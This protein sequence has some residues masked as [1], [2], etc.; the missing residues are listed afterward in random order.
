[1]R[2]PSIKSA[3]SLFCV[4]EALFLGSPCD[5]LRDFRG[6]LTTEGT[7]QAPTFEQNKQQK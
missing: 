3:E 4:A 2:Y 5:K 7:C 1:M 6:N